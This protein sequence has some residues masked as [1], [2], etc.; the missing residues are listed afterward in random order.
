MIIKWTVFFCALSIANV[1]YAHDTTH[2]HPLITAKIAQL[3][4]NTDSTDNYL[5]IYKDDPNKDTNISAEQ[6]LYWGT[7]FDAGKPLGGLT[8]EWLL[9]DQYRSPDEV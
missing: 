4:K 1:V 8:Q 2:I 7:D 3:I 5:D 6:L 9:E